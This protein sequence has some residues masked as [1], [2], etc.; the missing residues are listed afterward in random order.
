MMTRTA[1]VTVRP[2]LA[3]DM[4]IAMCVSREV[5]VSHNEFSAAVM[6]E[7]S[8]TNAEGAGGRVGV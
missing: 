5:L 1:Y 7:A 3:L 4:S 6:P 2:A 8:M